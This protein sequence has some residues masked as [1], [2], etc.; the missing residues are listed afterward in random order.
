MDKIKVPDCTISGDIELKAF[1]KNRNA[2]RDD[3]SEIEA[4]GSKFFASN[5][6]S[7]FQVKEQL[8]AE[9]F[10]CKNR[11]EDAD[12]ITSIEISDKYKE[13]CT[14]N[15][16][17]ILIFGFVP[18]HNTVE[19][20]KQE[21]LRNLYIAN[22]RSLRDQ[23]HREIEYSFEW[24]VQKASKV[25]A[26]HCRIYDGLESFIR[27]HKVSWSA[28]PTIK[29]EAYDIAKCDK[30]LRVFL[31][32][33]MVDRKYR[34]VLTKLTELNNLVYGVLS[35]T[36]Y[37]ENILDIVDSHI[38]QELAK[39]LDELDY[40]DSPFVDT[41]G[42]R[43]SVEYD[44]DHGYVIG[45]IKKN[46]IYYDSVSYL[47]IKQHQEEKENIGNGVSKYEQE[48]AYLY[49]RYGHANVKKDR[50]I[51]VN[52]ALLDA[53]DSRETTHILD[54]EDFPCMAAMARTGM[55][56]KLFRKYDGKAITITNNYL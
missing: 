9:A 48:M 24:F 8:L 50:F 10:R 7:I 32:A 41:S 12:T 54:M 38:K 25:K 43:A 33:N 37:G 35:T 20:S 45:G 30:R 18:R 44:D 13:F 29:Y 4:L 51:R 6:G 22:V 11:R 1:V 55:Y 19:L 2:K 28:N 15:N 16:S 23:I 46:A 17:P 47:E 31:I 14:N 53:G 3:V 34:K 39:P 40:D 52:P 26:K 27:K 56:G 21:V 42:Y 49:S 5:N 36:S